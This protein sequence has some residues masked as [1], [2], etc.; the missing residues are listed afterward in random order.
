MGTDDYLYDAVIFV[1]VSFCKE[2]WGVIVWLTG[3]ALCFVIEGTE[4][5]LLRRFAFTTLY[6]YVILCLSALKSH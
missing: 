3:Y 1:V 2:C 4:I 5:I 6:L